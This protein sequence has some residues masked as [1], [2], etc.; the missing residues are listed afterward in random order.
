MSKLSNSAKGILLATFAS[1]S[2]GIAGVITEFV[3]HAEA[4][5]A[6][7]F[8][9]ARTTG[10]GLIL[11]II[12]AI[13]Y[14]GKIFNV[15]KSWKSVMWIVL[16]GL[17]GLAAN[18]GSFYVSIQQGNA[19][20]A[21][22]LQYLAPLFIAIGSFL[23]MKKRPLK[24]DLLVFVIALLG[25]ALSITKGDFT[26]LSIS[27]PSFVW[28]I[29]AGITAAL[30]VVLPRNLA[31]DNSP[32]VVLGWGTLIASLAYNLNHPVFMD[33]PKLSNEA[34]LGIC[35]IILFGTLLTF[36]S[37][38]WATRFTS[39]EVI[40]L[41]DAAQPVSTFIFSIIFLG[42]PLSLWEVIGAIL[43]I[44]AVY[45]LQYAQRKREVLSVYSGPNFK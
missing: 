11:I 30:Y 4:I 2:W 9:S 10:A 44:A 16:Y 23:F 39:S 32:I 38:I 14:R 25:V 36:S 27:F 29:V 31:E 28:G 35:G 34:I 41:L 21:T 33:V 12:S 13:I 5:P 20:A 8:L 3:S 26:Q 40:S 42:T 22:I 19:A 24:I 18:M 6:D 15:F 1:I 37:L 7:W 45:I 17:L 43:V